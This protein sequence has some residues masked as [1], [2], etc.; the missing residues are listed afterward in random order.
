M[1][2]ARAFGFLLAVALTA[3][4]CTGGNGGSAASPSP[5]PS[6][7]PP[8][9]R[10]P[11]T[12]RVATGETD[13]ARP[14][15]AVKIEN[16]P[17]ARPQAGLERAD[18]VFEQV[19][20]GGITRFLAVF[21][22]R[23][24]SSIGPVRSAR[25]VDPDILAQL[26]RPVFAYSGGARR[27]LDVVESAGLVLLPHGR[28]GDAY[29]RLR[30][31]RAP[32][33]LF[34]STAA[35]YAAAGDQGTTPEPLFDY[36]ALPPPPTPSPSPSPSPPPDG[37]PSPVPSPAH[38]AVT[39]MQAAFSASYVATWRWDPVGARYLRFQGETPH[40]VV[41]G[42]QISA[43]NVIVM[44]VPVRDGGFRDAAGNPSPEIDVIGAGEA[45]LLRDGV[46]IPGR[47]QRASRA[48]RTVFTDDVGRP[49]VLDPGVTW[50]ELLPE[51]ADLQ[52][53]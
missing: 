41:S 13:L 7:P 36:G 15:L 8:P 46:G 39:D 20:E 40:A 2:R 16:T 26:G 21:H 10:Y 50:I 34:S 18:V 14:A 53:G 43:A 9:P 28:F 52:L 12:W 17:A 35:L 29:E 22:S 31:R 32:H 51:G 3:A 24:A 27:V 49:F 25:L 23:D 44:R 1:S 42:V 37:S 48:D 11:L 4:A 5:S 45:L 33:N 38:A 19:V 6:E 30:S 47:W